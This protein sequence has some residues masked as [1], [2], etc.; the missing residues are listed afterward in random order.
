MKKKV[1]EPEELKLLKKCR[2]KEHGK[3]SAEGKKAGDIVTVSGIDKLELLANKLAE[4]Y[5]PSSK[6]PKGM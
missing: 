4:P 3:T 6:V 5:T 2:V 1:D